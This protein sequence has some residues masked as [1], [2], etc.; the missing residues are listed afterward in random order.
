MQRR[1]AS[2]A[3]ESAKP[4]DLQSFPGGYDG[5]RFI[6]L[7]SRL[8][9]EQD[10]LF[11]L[12]PH[13][14]QWSSH[15]YLFDLHS[16][17]PYWLAQARRLHMEPLALLEKIL[18]TVFGDDCIAVLSASP[19]QAVLLLYQ[20]IDQGMRGVQVLGSRFN[21]RA[22][23]QLQWQHW[24]QALEQ[25]S[26]HLQ[27]LRVRHFNPAQLRARAAQLQRFIQR[28]ELAGPWQLKQAD[29]AAIARRYAGWIGQAWGWTFETMDP[30]LPTTR[31]KHP[32]RF[33]WRP[34][35][36][37]QPCNIKRHLEYPVSDWQVVEP[38]LREDLAKLCRIGHWS[39]GD[40]ISS[41]QW[42]ITLFNLQ[43]VT[44]DIR[45]RH[46]HALHREAP[47]FRTALYQAFYAYADMMQ[48]LT[49][50]DH[51]LELPE[52]MPFIGWQLEIGQRL[53]LPP[54]LLALFEDETADAGYQR[55]LDL[56][57]CLPADMEHYRI[58]ADFVPEQL[59]R[60][61]Q[62]GAAVD[63]N[64]AF[65]LQQW[66]PGALPRPLFFFRQP[67]PVEVRQQDCRFLERTACNWWQSENTDDYGRD[68]F[69]LRTPQGQLLWVFRNHAGEWYQHGIYS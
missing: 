56:Q 13:V 67:Q 42:R 34:L 44:V 30:A 31:Q 19:W 21:R 37:Q 64:A 55:I 1:Y 68:Y 20:R 48:T 22:Y 47:E 4:I 65:S 16:C 59:F 3:V 52:E 11:C 36:F 57:N 45:F 10:K 58:N 2:M 29:V 12:T 15:I 61:Q 38:L 54:V 63:R 14:M 51:D 50:R 24:F 62:P 18:L 41:L 32:R 66:L 17:M 23:G 43:Q 69:L 60:S 53:Q 40:K 5:S 39:P 9:P 26:Q 25:L 7:Y 49:Q 46:P 28:L 27:A 35:V 6:A 33:P 8:Q